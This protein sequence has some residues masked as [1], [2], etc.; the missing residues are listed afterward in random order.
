MRKISLLLFLLCSTSFVLLEGIKREKHCY[1]PKE[2]K[3][4]PGFSAVNGTGKGRTQASLAE[5]RML[6]EEL[7][8]RTLREAERRRRAYGGQKKSG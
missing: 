7:A 1:L 3:G 8:R 2:T 6:R 5:Q 4:K